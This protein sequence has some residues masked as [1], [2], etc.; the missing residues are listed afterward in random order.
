[1]P[2]CLTLLLALNLSVKSY[3]ALVVFLGTLNEHGQIS[4]LETLLL[5]T[6]QGRIPDSDALNLQKLSQLQTNGHG[7]M[8]SSRIFIK[9]LPPTISEDEF[10]KHFS[11]KHDITDAKLIPHRRIGYIGYKTPEDA[12]KAVKY[13]NKSFIRLS[14]IGVE[15]ARPVSHLA[16][17][18]AFAN[19]LQ[20][21]DSTLPVSR[22]L[23]R[24]Q[25]REAAIVN[26]KQR[27][28]ETPPT[29]LN[30]GQKRKRSD[31]DESDHKLKEFLEVMQPASKAKSWITQDEND[32]EPPTKIQAIEIPHAESDKEYEEVPKNHKSKTP[33]RLGDTPPVTDV[34][35]LEAEENVGNS[36][37]P[38][39]TDDDWLRSR[40]SRL[41]DLIDPGAI[42][43]EQVRAHSPNI[44]VVESTTNIS[45]K[46]FKSPAAEK[47]PEM[48]EEQPDQVIEAIKS[49]GRLFVRN[50][51]YTATEQDLRE[52]FQRYGLLEEVCF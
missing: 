7:I 44:P 18:L 35:P 40:S 6:L 42:A 25:A 43:A 10:K 46:Y 4:D 48:E 15:I 34:A 22:K 19:G 51:P 11:V 37:A 14:K 52:H 29:K 2:Y 17:L 21:T 45:K 3:S 31:V 8:A 9:G 41:L 32:A 49:N 24:E 50:L 30:D 23:Q 16:F 20:I 13:F 27:L 39:A 36:N 5:L 38:D 33:P 47:T 26:R 1:M 12:A 28:E